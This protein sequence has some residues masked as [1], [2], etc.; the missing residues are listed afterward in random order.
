MK[1]FF[2]TAVLVFS[3]CSH[4]LARDFVLDEVLSDPPQRDSSGR[5]TAF[6]AGPTTYG[7]YVA[8]SYQTNDCCDT[9][10]C[11]VLK[12]YYLFKLIAIP[13]PFIAY[14]VSKSSKHPMESLGIC[15]AVGCLPN[16]L[17]SMYDFMYFCSCTPNKRPIYYMVTCMGLCMSIL[18][19]AC[20]VSAACLSLS[21]DCHPSVYGPDCVEKIDN[22]TTCQGL[23][24]SA[25]VVN[26]LK[27]FRSLYTCCTHR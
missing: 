18:S 12:C 7:T 23:V 15:S 5:Y 16:F 20:L 25:G 4:A 8:G 27:L 2:A 26:A 22:L 10:Y 6:F 24:I 17:E 3:L 11:Q 14:G 9:N 21:Q 19:T 13:L 1:K